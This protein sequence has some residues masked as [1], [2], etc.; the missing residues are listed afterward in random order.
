MKLKVK[1]LVF[2]PKLVELRPINLVYV[3]RYRQAYRSG[4][5]LGTIIV[6]KKTKRVVSGNHRGVA[7]Q[8]EY[9]PEHVIDVEVVSF[10]SEKEILERFVTENIAHG[11]PLSGFSRKSIAAELLKF[12]A[13]P[14]EIANLF[15]V[16]VKRIEEWAGITVVV[17]SGNG[18][19]KREIKTAKRGI[20]VGTEMSKEEYKTHLQKDR[21]ISAYSQAEQLIRWINSGFINLDCKRTVQALEDLRTSLDKFFVVKKA[22]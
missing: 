6:D 22:A 20:P 5:D 12:K 18:D 11:Q 10:N 9:G 3:S 19:K 21:G 1:N 15:G 16:A 2:D 17:I 4:K 7:L 14:E 8:Q 13:T